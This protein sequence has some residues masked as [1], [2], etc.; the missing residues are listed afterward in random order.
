MKNK[1]DNTRKRRTNHQP[2]CQ[3][4]ADSKLTDGTKSD[5]AFRQVLGDVS[6]LKP[7]LQSSEGSQHFTQPS[8][9]FE[10]VDAPTNKARKCRLTSSYFFYNNERLQKKTFIPHKKTKEPSPIVY[11][12]LD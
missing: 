2:T 10:N 11:S 6:N 8:T 7:N 12:I 3:S 9:Y 4:L 5:S 1:E